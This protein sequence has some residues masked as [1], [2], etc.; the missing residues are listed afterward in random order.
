MKFDCLS[1]KRVIQRLCATHDTLAFYNAAG[2]RILIRYNPPDDDEDMAFDICIHVTQET[3]GH[4]KSALE[5][6]TSVLEED[7]DVYV[8]DEFVFTPQWTPN[9]RL[10][11]AL[12]LLQSLCR[13]KVCACG[14]Y[15]V[16]DPD[17]ANVC[18]YCDLV[19]TRGH[20]APHTVC[21]ICCEEFH[22][23]TAKRQ[24]SCCGKIIDNAC[25]LRFVTRK[26]PFC[27][28]PLSPPVKP[29][30]PEESSQSIAATP[31]EVPSS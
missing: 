23:E 27:R 24:L 11:D 16:K 29:P 6:E 8:L 17:E 30:P 12:S 21:A 28:A 20:R 26:C 10:R 2:L 22:A 4:I 1:F 14:K 13:W 5:N 25:Y 18:L 31:P 9:D 7:E 19:T 15:F 3:H